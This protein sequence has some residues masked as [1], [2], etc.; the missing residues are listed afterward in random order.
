MPIPAHKLAVA[1]LCSTAL[2]LTTGDL[3]IREASAAAQVA[4]AQDSA[5]QL[6]DGVTLHLPS[7]IVPSTLR[8]SPL[9]ANANLV[10]DAANSAAG[11]GVVPVFSQQNTISIPLAKPTEESADAKWSLYGLGGAPGAFERTGQTV[12]T[13]SFN[14]DGKVSIATPWIMA[15]RPDGTGFGVLADSMASCRFVCAA[16]EIT[17]ATTEATL[18]IIIIEGNSPEQIL[19]RLGTVF[20]TPAMPPHWSLGWLQISD[21]AE[22]AKNAAEQLRAAKVPADAIWF[23]PKATEQTTGVGFDQTTFPDPKAFIADLKAK[24]YS[25]VWSGDTVFPD[26]PGRWVRDQ[27]ANSKFALSNTKNEQVTITN[28]G[29]ASIAPDFSRD[30]VRQ[31]WATLQKDIAASGVDAVALGARPLAFLNTDTRL[32]G[33]KLGDATLP[34]GPGTDYRGT[35]SSLATLATT[36]G[37]R[38]SRPG[39]RPLVLSETN[40]LG[41]TRSGASIVRV[42]A[43]ADAASNAAAQ[44]L[45]LGLSG[46]SMFAASSTSADSLGVA[47]LFP[48]AAGSAPLWDASAV[49]NATLALNRRARL[50]PYLYTAMKDANETGVPIVRPVFFADPANTALRSESQGFLLGRDLLVVPKS[51]AADAP[52]R[53]ALIDGPYTVPA[54]RWQR[55]TLVGEAENAALPDLY[56]RPGAII[57]LAPIRQNNKESYGGPL[58]LLVNLDANGQANGEMYEDLGEGDD[59][60]AGRSLRTGYA[61][62]TAEGKLKVEVASKE[63]SFARPSRDLFLVLMREDGYTA[64]KGVDGMSLT[65]DP[66]RRQRTP[67]NEPRPLPGHEPVPPKTLH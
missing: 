14:A 59:Y 53:S 5:Y 56:I 23:S 45:S 25:I 44:A 28:N 34:G 12:D 55:I 27:L 10:R 62:S 18:P 11:S 38:K 36:E 41:L 3:F 26:V 40:S 65:F 19:S 57:P 16:N 6:A 32:R 50:M 52:V 22:N 4:R 24:G 54:S 58:T 63:G 64:V 37:L 60:L 35:Y 31:W 43:N 1:A 7:S 46:Q 61:A 39:L 67:M 49:A 21:S 9:F 51:V 13:V 29:A 30:D 17:I 20:G 42:D 2:T 15:L 8:A 66:N 47:S 48:I 33:G